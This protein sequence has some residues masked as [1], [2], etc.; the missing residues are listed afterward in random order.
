MVNARKVRVIIDTSLLPETSDEKVKKAL[1]A[2]LAGISYAEDHTDIV[3]L[4]GDN[5]E[6]S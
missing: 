1:R 3:V 5:Y 4:W 6:Q 2:A